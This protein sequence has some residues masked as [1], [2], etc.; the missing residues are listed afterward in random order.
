MEKREKKREN[1]VYS[2]ICWPNNVHV[3]YGKKG[4]KKRSFFGYRLI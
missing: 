3:N 2:N 1:G 4:G